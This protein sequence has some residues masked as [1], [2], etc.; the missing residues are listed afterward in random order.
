[1][2]K[3]VYV[4]VCVMVHSLSVQGVLQGGYVTSSRRCGCRCSRDSVLLATPYIMTDT[5]FVLLSF[6]I[7]SAV[8]PHAHY[9]GLLFILVWHVIILSEYLKNFYWTHFLHQQLP[10]FSSDV[11]AEQQQSISLPLRQCKKKDDQA[12]QNHGN[13]GALLQ[14]T[15]SYRTIQILGNIA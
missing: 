9:N 4:C 7:F 6:H 8:L 2:S 5:L 14:L 13:F 11:G 15:S 12:S 3:C 10:G 1:M